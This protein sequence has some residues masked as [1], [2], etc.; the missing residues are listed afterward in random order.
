MLILSSLLLSYLLT[1]GGHRRFYAKAAAD[2]TIVCKTC[3]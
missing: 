3:L 2:A 1:D